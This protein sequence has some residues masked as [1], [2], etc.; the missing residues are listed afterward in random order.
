MPLSHLRAAQNVGIWSLLAFIIS[1]GN[2]VWC[3]LVPFREGNFLPPQLT[4]WADWVLLL[5]ECQFLCNE[6]SVGLLGPMFY[7]KCREAPGSVSTLLHC[8]TLGRV[9]PSVLKMGV[10]DSG[11]ELATVLGWAA[12][13]DRRKRPSGLFNWRLLK[14]WVLCYVIFYLAW[15]TWFRSQLLG[16]GIQSTFS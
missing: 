2:S 6:F 8:H 9:R 4:Q 5:N 15:P 13:C 3:H 10:F 11:L 16:I 12:G 7:K 14:L 1:L